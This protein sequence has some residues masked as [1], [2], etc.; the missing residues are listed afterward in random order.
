MRVLAMA[1]AVS[2]LAAADGVPDAA[3]KEM[4]L[5]EGEWSMVSGER[6]GTVVPK[7][8]VKDFKRV[9]QGGVTTVTLK[10]QLYSKS[11]FTLDPS[12]RPKN[13]D[14]VVLEGKDK[15]K[16]LLGIYERDGDKVTFCFAA[17]GKERPTDFT[18]G[19]GSERT[20]SVWQRIKKE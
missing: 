20:K 19:D 12:T 13:I 15:G 9:A 7:S 2:F 1:M 14:Y 16:K 11:S 5:L 6:D 8:L 4:E 10:G 18:A 3:K 17:P